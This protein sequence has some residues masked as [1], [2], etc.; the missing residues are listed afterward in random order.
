MS[1]HKKVNISF[2]LFYLCTECTEWEILN[3]GLGARNDLQILNTESYLFN[4]KAYIKKFG[5]DDC[6]HFILQFHKK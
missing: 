3:L 2:S 4:L 1:S 5:I 6:L